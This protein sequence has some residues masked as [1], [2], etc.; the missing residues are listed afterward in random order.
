MLLVYEVEPGTYELAYMWL[1]TWIGMNIEIK[2]EIETYIHNRFVGKEATA[3]DMHDAVVDYLCDKFPDI[4]G[5]RAYL[6][7]VEQV[8]TAGTEE[9]A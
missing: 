5:L 9:Q 7:V 3:R 8:T 4:N 6:T 2:K 1:P